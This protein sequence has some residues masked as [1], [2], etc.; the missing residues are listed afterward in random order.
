MEKKNTQKLSDM[1]GFFF[2]PMNNVLVFQFTLRFNTK[3]SILE[4]RLS[5]ICSDTSWF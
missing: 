5:E 3:P 2:P 4:V 1:F